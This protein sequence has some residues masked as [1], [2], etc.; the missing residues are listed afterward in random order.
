MAD[1]WEGYADCVGTANS[2]YKNCKKEK[3]CDQRLFEAK[4]KCDETFRKAREAKDEEVRDT[5]RKMDTCFANALEQHWRCSDDVKTSL[6]KYEACMN[7]ITKYDTDLE[8][9]WSVQGVKE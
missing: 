6:A 9:K 5:Y 1:K 7:E 2:M 3:R 8:K 4:T